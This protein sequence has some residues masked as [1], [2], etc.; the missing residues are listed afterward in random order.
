MGDKATPIED[1]AEKDAQALRGKGKGKA[2]ATAGDSANPQGSGGK[3]GRKKGDSLGGGVKAGSYRK[4]T[5][6]DTLP[7]ILQNLIAKERE[8][9]EILKSEDTSRY[10]EL[11]NLYSE[12]RG[13][14]AK[15]DKIIKQVSSP[16][17]DNKDTKYV[18]IQYDKFIN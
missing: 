16:V 8:A 9:R 11:P 10:G 7:G 1:Q 17:D 2:G 14:E 3:Y 6:D 4:Q 13:L 15:R 5:V 12:I 18:V